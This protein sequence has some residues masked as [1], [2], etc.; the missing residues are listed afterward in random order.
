MNENSARATPPERA[1]SFRFEASIGVAVLLTFASQLLPEG[2]LPTALG[3]TL[4]TILIVFVPG[5][6]LLRAFGWPDTPS[7]LLALS[8]IWSIAMVG[9]S[10]W[11]GFALET[12]VSGAIMIL[13]VLTLGAIAAGHGRPLPRYERA[14]ILPF[15]VAFGVGCLFALVVAWD[16]VAS[17]TAGDWIEHLG[18]VRK[19]TSL[20][21]LSSLEAI[22]IVAPETGLH[23]VYAFPLWH[24]SMA[25]IASISGL[26]PGSVVLHISVLLAPLAAVAA[27]HAGLMVFGSRRLGLAVLAAQLAWAAFPWRVGGFFRQSYPGFVSV[28]ILFPIALALLFAHLRRRDPHTLA[29]LAVTALLISVLHANYIPLLLIP[30]GAFLALHA[31]MERN[32]GTLRRVIEVGAAL[33][34]PFLLFLPWI[35]P[36]ASAAGTSLD[37]A[38]RRAYAINHFVTLLDLNGDS[39]RMSADAFLRGGGALVLATGLVPFCVLAIRRRWGAFVVASFLTTMVVL[40]TYP[41]F[42]ALSELMNIGQSRRLLYFLPVPFAIVG[43]ALVL[44]RHRAAPVIAPVLGTVVWLLYPGESSYAMVKP[45]P[46]WLAW[47]SL[48]ALAAGVVF[49]VVR[50]LDVNLAPTSLAALTASLAVAPVLAGNAIGELPERQTAAQLLPPG[51]VDEFNDRVPPGANVFGNPNDMWFLVALSPID[52]NAVRRGHGGD[53][54]IALLHDR[55]NDA[56]S[57]FYSEPSEDEAMNL[58]EEYEAEW[59]LVNETDVVPEITSELPLEFRAEG[60]A[61]YRV[62]DA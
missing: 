28:T 23:P 4:A 33:V 26:D 20:P 52:A 3:L 55:Y 39:I 24:G 62:P 8:A 19:I 38:Y 44:S 25:Y 46:G 22:Q 1:K 14:D 9:L 61:V 35:W 15:A 18:R 56:M 43:A 31:W 48:A 16:P 30:V 40:L 32:R 17:V 11:A 53:T 13:A 34:V 27:Y 58:L 54:T 47:L 7:A 51:F 45:G 12:H 37:P 60:Y 59:L 10:L 57:F 49:A 21:R 6:A 42:R 36:W 2:P 5:L 29:A 50:R 41:G